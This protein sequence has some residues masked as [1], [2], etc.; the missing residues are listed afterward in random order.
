MKIYQPQRR[1]GKRFVTLGSDQIVRIM[2]SPLINPHV[3]ARKKV[4]EFKNI[5]P[6]WW[7]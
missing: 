3:S 7:N 2:T 1:S 5:N 6:N 4:F